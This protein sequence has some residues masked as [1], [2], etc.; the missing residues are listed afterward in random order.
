MWHPQSTRQCYLQSAGLTPGLWRILP[1]TTSR[2][3][4]TPEIQQRCRAAAHSTWLA[5]AKHLPQPRWTMARREE[6]RGF[7]FKQIIARAA[8]FPILV[9]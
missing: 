8:P 2:L 5:D 3:Q 1:Q 6:Q 9:W 4:I 7:V